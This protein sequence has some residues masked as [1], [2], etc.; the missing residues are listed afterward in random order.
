MELY[1]IRHAQSENNALWEQSGSNQGRNM[2]PGLSDLGSQQALALAQFLAQGNGSAGIEADFHNRKGFNFSHLYSSLMLRSVMTGAIIAEVLAVPLIAWPDWHEGGG[3]YLAD[4]DTNEP[5]GQ[6]GKDRA[7]FEENYPDLVLP[8][9][10]GDEGWWNRPFEER[11]A[12]WERARRVQRELFRRHGDTS[13]RVAVV[14]HGGFS[15]YFLKTLFETSPD[16]PLWFMFNNAAITRVDFNE[17]VRLVYLNRVDY[18]P[19]ELI[20]KT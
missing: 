1:L 12:R 15:N 10:L 11:P 16:Q 19:E 3:I 7:Y 4:Q 13:D 17:E 18:L 8:A 9:D 6:A 20:S 5:V 14:T 2:D